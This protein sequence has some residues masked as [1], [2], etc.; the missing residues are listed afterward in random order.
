MTLA[1]CRVNAPSVVSFDGNTY[2]LM[3]DKDGQRLTDADGNIIVEETD[4]EGNTVTEVLSDD[5]LIIQDDYTRLRS[6]NSQGFR[7]HKQ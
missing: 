7:N 3:T 2:E 6:K 4:E 5:Y 1:S